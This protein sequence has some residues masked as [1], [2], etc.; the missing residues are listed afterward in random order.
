MLSTS[1]WAFSLLAGKRWKQGSLVWFL[2]FSV[3]QTHQ[4]LAPKARQ[5]IQRVLQDSCLTSADLLPRSGSQKPVEPGRTC[6][7][8]AYLSLNQPKQHSRGKKCGVV[9]MPGIDVII[10]GVNVSEKHG[11]TP[12]LSC[13]QQLHLIVTLLK[14]TA[15]DATQIGQSANINYCIIN[16]KYNIY[17]YIC[18]CKYNKF[19]YI[20]IYECRTKV[21]VP[22]KDIIK[23]GRPLSVISVW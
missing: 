19:K 20:Y 15:G 21:T 1:C 16:K 4:L 7:Y 17:I 9:C 14:K 13:Y 5:M 2:T 11:A 22:Q 12:T 8:T 18:I 10:K 3:T 6:R 23:L